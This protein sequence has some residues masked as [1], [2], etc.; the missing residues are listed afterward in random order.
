MSTSNLQGSFR[1]GVPTSDIEVTVLDCS[2]S[3]SREGAVGS[4]GNIR[5]EGNAVC[6]AYQAG[7]SAG[8]T[9]DGAVVVGRPKF[10]TRFDVTVDREELV[11]V[12]G[13]DAA[14]GELSCKRLRAPA[15][16]GYVPDT[17]EREVGAGPG[18]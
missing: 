9:Y 16:V 18:M 4:A 8:E 3:V 15:G 11:E 1:A 13:P 2:A 10:E 7:G 14:S 17:S 5:R 12:F 6:G